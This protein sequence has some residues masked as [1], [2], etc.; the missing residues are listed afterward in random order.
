MKNFQI[1]LAE[2]QKDVESAQRLRFEVFNLEMKKGLEASYA[3]GLDRDAY[4]PLCD[5]ILIIDKAKE[6]AIG[7]YRL[8]LKSRLGKGDFFYSENEF[9]LTNIRKL[10][11][12][13]MEMGRSCV[14]KDYRSSAI[15]LL[16]WGGIVEY[17]KNHDVKYIIGCPSLYTTDP[18]EIGRIYSLMRKDHFSPEAFRVTPRP[19][20]ELK[21]LK[22]VPVAEHERRGILL[23]LPALVRSYL[24]TGAYV[25]GAPAVDR[26]FGTVDLFMLLDVAH[27]SQQYL[28]RLNIRRSS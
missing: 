24:K 16:L 10:K 14:H 6:M 26:E 21:G 19:D 23:K 25:C 4:D 15:V 17:M 7:T 18:A 22:E 5:H 13:I 28:E 11:G 3:E 2:T 8:L 27:L 12:E 20:K 9:D 1:R